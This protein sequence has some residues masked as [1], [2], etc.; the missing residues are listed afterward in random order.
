MVRKCVL[1]ALLV[2]LM[3]VPVVPARGAEDP[4]P[5]SLSAFYVGNW[6]INDSVPP[7]HDELAKSAGK[8]WTVAVRSGLGLTLYMNLYYFRYGWAYGDTQVWT[9]GGRGKLK[10]V[11]EGRPWDALV[12]QPHGWMGLHRDKAQMGRWYTEQL[13]EQLA[14]EDFGDVF[15]AGALFRA[16]LEHHPE[17]ELVVLEEVPELPQKRGPDREFVTQDT[18]AG[19]EPAPDREEFDYV[20]HWETVKYD[21]DQGE[22]GSTHTTRDYTRRLMEELK[23]RFP[24]KWR[25]GKLRCIPVG[26]VYNTLE[27]RIRAG[28]LS[29]P[30]GVTSFYSGTFHQ[31]TGL[32]RYV[33][34]A[35]MYAT[36]F[37]DRPHSLDWSVYNTPGAYRQLGGPNWFYV[38]EPDL[39]EH[40][41]ITAD[42]AEAVNDTIWQVATEHPYAGVDAD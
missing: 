38:H 9:T 17:G 31:R 12:V 22:E 41:E 18:V 30:G 39:G 4:G 20:R 33:L 34:A 42:L 10:D 1:A 36:L 25:E 3:A 24:E 6:L 26:E 19:P 23:A 8:E 28:E 37:R 40:M 5:E 2:L 21:A 15:S 27:K 13:A 32:P 14:T 16:Y 29:L 7:F 35:T 11:F